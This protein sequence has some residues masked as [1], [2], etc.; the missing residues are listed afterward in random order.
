MNGE[1]FK[2]GISDITQV[3]MTNQQSNLVWNKLEEY[4]NSNPILN[5]KVESPWYIRSIYFATT[6][7]G[8]LVL[9]VVFVS[10]VSLNS[11]FIAKDSLPG[12]TLYSL[13]VD[14]ME[15]LEYSFAVDSVAKNNILLTNL[16]KR[17]KEVEAL[18]A[19]GR[20]TDSIQNDLEKR[21]KNDTKKILEINNN[22][23]SK[24][25]K[26][27]S[28]ES[29]TAINIEDSAPVPVTMMMVS[30]SEST[31]STTT[32]AVKNKK[33]SRSEQ[34]I[35]STKA[36]VERIKKI[37]KSNKKFLEAAEESIRKAED[38]LKNIERDRESDSHSN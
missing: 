16:D 37:K 15:P 23:N 35:R 18:D 31:S 17:L 19:G 1:N 26:K 32:E 29:R 3:R 38:S 22:N 13:K 34:L 27:P 6:R 28:Q 4:T 12:D 21:L 5:V 36:S 20:L 7:T 14:V 8:G 30:E 2:K 24:V 9:S 25:L 33:E 10:L 11:V